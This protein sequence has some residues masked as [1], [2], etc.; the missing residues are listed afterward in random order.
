MSWHD[1]VVDTLFGSGSTD[2]EVTSLLWKIGFGFLALNVI[3][4]LLP[5][6][7]PAPYGRYQD[8]VSRALTCMYERSLKRHCLCSKHRLI[9]PT[10]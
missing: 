9:K 2:A 5:F 10:A 6:I 4:H 1:W 3:N 8:G 7:G